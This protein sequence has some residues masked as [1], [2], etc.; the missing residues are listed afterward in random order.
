MKKAILIIVALFLLSPSAFA[1]TSEEY[2]ALDADSQ[3]L[4]DD[5]YWEGYNDAENNWLD[6]ADE[7]YKEGYDEGYNDGCDSYFENEDAA[8]DDG[9]DSGYDDGYNDALADA[10]SENDELT[11]TDKLKNAIPYILFF[12]LVP[13]AFLFSV[14]MES[15]H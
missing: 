5:G 9:Y 4:Y 7:Q 1:L 3:S 10:D 13:G 11:F 14:W 6:F 2:N 15:N 8:Y 12:T